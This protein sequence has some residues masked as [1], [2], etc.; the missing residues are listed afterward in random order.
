MMDLCD[1]FSLKGVQHAA[2]TNLSPLNFSLLLNHPPSRTSLH[3]ENKRTILIRKPLFSS[4]RGNST[5]PCNACPNRCPFWPWNWGAAELMLHVGSFL[6]ILHTD[7][8]AKNSIDRH[9]FSFAQGGRK[10]E[11]SFDG[12]S[13]PI[14]PRVLRCHCPKLSSAAASYARNNDC[15]PSS[16]SSGVPERKCDINIFSLFSFSNRLVEVSWKKSGPKYVAQSRGWS[17]IRL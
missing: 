1:K 2:K 11:A 6:F 15:P 10:K 7:K 4:I 12:P 3:I 8:K 17:R 9:H 5:Q 14:R 16:S 13:A